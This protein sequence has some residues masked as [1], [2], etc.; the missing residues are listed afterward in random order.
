M[1]LVLLHARRDDDAGDGDRAPEVVVVVH[2]QHAVEPQL[3][4]LLVVELERE[5]VRGRDVELARDARGVVVRVRAPVEALVTR[6]GV[7]THRLDGPPRA[8]APALGR[9]A[10]VE[11]REFEHQVRGT[12]VQVRD[13]V[14]VAVILVHRRLETRALLANGRGRVLAQIVPEDVREGGEDDRGEKDVH[15]GRG[16]EGRR[17]GRTTGELSPGKRGVG[18][19]GAHGGKIPAEEPNPSTVATRSTPRVARVTSE[20]G[21]R[22]RR[23]RRTTR[24]K[25]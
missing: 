3:R 16:R 17:A 20:Q 6:G 11:I 8:R 5:R 1:D 23:L 10:V 15:N 24:K 13:G 19:G 25:Y 2:A 21:K 12:R 18:G 7:E 22:P 4:A 9:Q 14:Q